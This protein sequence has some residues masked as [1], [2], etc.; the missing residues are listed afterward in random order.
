MKGDSEFLEY[1]YG[2]YSLSSKPQ[3]PRETSFLSRLYEA[4]EKGNGNRGK[5]RGKKSGYEGGPGPS[6][7]PHTGGENLS[8]PLPTLT[9]RL[10]GTNGTNLLNLRSTPKGLPL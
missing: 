1:L 4:R 8:V 9:D 6:R 5:G 10:G 2:N 7:N 3:G